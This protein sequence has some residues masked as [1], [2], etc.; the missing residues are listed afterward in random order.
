MCGYRN[1]RVCLS[2]DINEGW[3]CGYSD[4]HGY[5]VGVLRDICINLATGMDV[6]ID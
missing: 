6:C 4:E 3:V 5:T 1:R 2:G